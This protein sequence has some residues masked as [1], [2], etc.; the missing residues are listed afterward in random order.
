MQIIVSHGWPLFC[1]A[2]GIVLFT[3]YIMARL[4]RHFYTMDVVL[5]KF[6]IMDLQ[7]PDSPTEL[8]NLVRGIFLLPE[9]RRKKCLKALKSTLYIDFLFMP[10]AYGAVFLLCMKVMYKMS[11]FGQYFFMI[12]A[13]LQVLALIFDIIENIYLLKKIHPG[14][15]ASSVSVHKTLQFFALAKWGIALVSII[16]A[17]SGALDVWLVGRYDTVSLKYILILIGEVVL[18]LLAGML[19]KKIKQADF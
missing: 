3:A 6:S 14:V 11:F 9:E 5:R 8:K 19:I 18:F 4:S 17:L 10:A 12:L 13:W 2:F 16:C 1:V 7:L 15:E